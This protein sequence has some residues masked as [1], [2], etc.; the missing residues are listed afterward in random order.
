LGLDS[1]W[2]VSAMGVSNIQVSGAFRLSN[3]REDPSTVYGVSQYRPLGIHR[4]RSTNLIRF[5]ALCPLG[6]KNKD[7]AWSLLPS[8]SVPFKTRQVYRFL[9]DPQ[10]LPINDNWDIWKYLELWRRNAVPRSQ[11]PTC[12]IPC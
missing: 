9:F 2:Y 10:I 7:I 1:P 8:M 5:A 3:R 11:T 12:R 4:S 6:N